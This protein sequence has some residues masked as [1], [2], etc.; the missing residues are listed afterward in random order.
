MKKV[1]DYSIERIEEGYIITENDLHRIAAQDSDSLV[2]KVDNS[3]SK[4]L[5]LK[6]NLYLSK[7]KNAKIKIIV[8]F[9]E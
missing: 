9:F 4:V 1:I 3:V 5:D 6:G 8:E 2:K 7:Y